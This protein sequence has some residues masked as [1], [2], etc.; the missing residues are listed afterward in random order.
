MKW[1]NTKGSGDEKIFKIK[2]FFK[3]IPM[4]QYKSTKDK[5]ELNKESTSSEKTPLCGCS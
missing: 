3:G 2:I 1:K 5:K 4:G